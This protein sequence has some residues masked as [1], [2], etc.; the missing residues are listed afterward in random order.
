MRGSIGGS[1]GLFQ[2]GELAPAPSDIDLNEGSKASLAVVIPLFDSLGDEYPVKTVDVRG[3][4][5]V[6]C[7]GV[8]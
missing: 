1:T 8:S 3:K 6:D 7:L 4:S 2:S 5:H